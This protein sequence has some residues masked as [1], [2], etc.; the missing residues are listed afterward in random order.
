MRFSHWNRRWRPIWRHRP[1]P[2]G[3]DCLPAFDTCFF[4]FGSYLAR[5]GSYRSH[6][7]GKASRHLCQDR[8]ADSYRGCADSYRSGADSYR[9]GF[10]T[11]APPATPV[12]HRR[13]AIARPVFANIA[14]DF[15]KRT[16]LIPIIPTSMAVSLPSTPV[17]RQKIAAK[18]AQT[19]SQ[20]IGNKALTAKTVSLAVFCPSPPPEPETPPKTAPARRPPATRRA[21]AFA[22]SIG[23]SRS[24]AITIDQGANHEYSRPVTPYA[25]SK[26]RPITCSASAG[27]VTMVAGRGFHASCVAR[28]QN[29]PVGALVWLI[30]RRHDLCDGVS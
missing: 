30:L 24:A 4:G 9:D 7:F 15:A 22:I 27:R 25:T 13:I 26:M 5:F 18:P 1:I 12:A 2:A 14:A 28:A 10:D 8:P 16:A 19:A 11:L 21:D 3:L 6:Y 17:F 29:G 23:G 20:R